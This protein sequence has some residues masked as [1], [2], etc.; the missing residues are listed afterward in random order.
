MIHVWTASGEIR[1]AFRWIV[2]TLQE[3]QYKLSMYV[4]A[5]LLVWFDPDRA[6]GGALEG[7]IIKCRPPQQKRGHCETTLTLFSTRPFYIRYNFPAIKLFH[8]NPK[9]KKEEKTFANVLK[10]IGVQ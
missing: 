10:E 3:R 1:M 2:R 5:D 6:A 7:S 4:M 8:F 9:K